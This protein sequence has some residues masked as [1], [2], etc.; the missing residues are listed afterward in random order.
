MGR[1]A[2]PLVSVIVPAFHAQAFIADAV[3]SVLA[4]RDAP[5]FEIVVSPDDGASYAHLRTLAPPDRLRILSPRGHHG[6]SAA[7]NRAL[8]VAR[9]RFIALCDADDLWPDR[10][11]ARLMPL[12]V[13]D[14]MACANTRYTEWGGELVRIP[15]LAGPRLTLET[16]GRCLASIRPLWNRALDVRFQDV[17]AEDVLHVLHLVALAEHGIPIAPE[18]DYQLRIRSGSATYAGLPR[19][20]AILAAYEPL[21]ASAADAPARI[22]LE[23]VPEHRRRLIVTALRFWRFANAAYL[24]TGCAASFMHYVAGREAALWA[25]YAAASRTPGGA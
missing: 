5:E 15:P 7:R 13:R 21:I 11:L 4:Q 20:Q 12:A 10:Y 2:V 3:R 25:A 14:G 6:V 18:T 9:G 24:A 22:G 19:Q 17:F 23:R 16:C 8:D 1:P